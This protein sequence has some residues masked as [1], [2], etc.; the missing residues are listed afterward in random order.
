MTSGIKTPY[1]VV[2]YPGDLLGKFKDSTDALRVA[3]MWSARRGKWAEVSGPDGLI[4]QFNFGE[5][6]AEFE[7]VRKI[8][9][10][11][12]EQP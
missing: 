1:H 5:P 10:P 9:F 7:H 3:Q 11:W 6:S 4:G 2:A 8:V 12:G